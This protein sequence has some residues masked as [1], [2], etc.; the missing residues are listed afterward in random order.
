MREI[1]VESASGTK[2]IIL[3]QP[4][5]L[6]R[7]PGNAATTVERPT[8]E[9]EEIR[10]PVAPKEEVSFNAL[11]AVEQMLIAKSS[12]ALFMPIKRR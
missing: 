6:F 1:T 10:E 7:Y 2:V 4:V 12:V 8:S 11:F 5:P 9:L 3:V